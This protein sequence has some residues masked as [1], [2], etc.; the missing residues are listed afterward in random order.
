MLF[1]LVHSLE[2]WSVW[3]LWYH[4]MQGWDTE[5]VW[6]IEDLQRPTPCDWVWEG[7]RILAALVPQNLPPACPHFTISSP[8]G[9]HKGFC[10]LMQR[11]VRHL[12][13]CACSAFTYAHCTSEASIRAEDAV[14]MSK[15]NKCALCIRPLH[16]SDGQPARCWAGEVWE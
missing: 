8:Q 14:H 7:G 3:Y 10:H 9:W 1:V 13:T 11:P 4:R 2:C 16:P 12:M 5:L 15:G 6:D